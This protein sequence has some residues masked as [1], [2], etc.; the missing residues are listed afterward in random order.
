MILFV[1]S[2][3]WDLGIPQEVATVVYKDNDACTAMGNAQKPTPRTCHMDIK[4]FCFAN[5]SSAILCTLNGSIL[6]STWPTTSQK[7]S[8]VLY[9]TGTRTSSWAIFHLYIHLFINQLWERIRINLLILNNTFPSH[10]PPLCALLQPEFMPRSLKIMQTIPG[11][12]Y[13]YGMVSTIHYV[14]RNRLWGGVIVVDRY[15]RPRLTLI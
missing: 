2:V 13:Y 15:I 1:R 12:L 7:D 8:H 6:R 3:I 14:V 10:S 9:F 4:Y 5:G 11:S